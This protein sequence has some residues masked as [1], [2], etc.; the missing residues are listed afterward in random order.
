M[1]RKIPVIA[2]VGRTNVGKSTLFNQITGRKL[3]VVDDHHGVTRD[4]HYALVN[5]HQFPF[6]LI[7]TGGLIGEEDQNLAD[8]IARQTRLAINEADAVVVLFDGIHGPHPHDEEVVQ[9][10]RRSNKPTLW[11]VNKSE[12]PGVEL[13]SSEFYGLGLDEI[14]TISAAHNV[15][16]P[17]LLVSLRKTLGITSEDTFEKTADED[18]PVRVAII[19][20]PNAGKSTLIN[21][22]LGEE[23]VIASPTAGTTRDRISIPVK[24]DGKEFHIIDTA[25]LRKKA[26]VESS[27]VERYS[28]LRAL[29]EVA[30]AD[31]AVLVIDATLGDPSEQDVRIAG[32]VHERG[33]G[34]IIA[35]NKWDSVEKDHTT[36]HTFKQNIQDCFKFA[37]YAPILFISALSGRRCVQVLSTAG[38]VH[39]HNHHRISTAQVNRVFERA[40]TGFPPPRYRGEPVK[41]Y[42]ATQIE[43]A[44]PTFVLFL[45]HPRKINFGYQRYL[46]NTLRK[47]FPYEGSPVRLLLRKRTPQDQKRRALQDDQVAYDYSETDYNSETD[48][49]AAYEGEEVIV[50]DYSVDPDGAHDDSDFNEEMASNS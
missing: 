44:P 48:Y 31:V 6:V 37:R 3:A 50:S 34:L 14:H 38:R 45:N 25:G 39:E 8:G 47:E 24:R 42:F 33:K 30:I 11:V 13:A 19:G 10:L 40:F 2:I 22:I 43:V 21:K 20:K 17:Q 29:R 32:L 15:G 28:N 49:T 41:L 18:A 16:I 12:K 23:R 46:L 1:A 5:K 7:D 4:R 26:R 35:V 36:A 27:S 9:L